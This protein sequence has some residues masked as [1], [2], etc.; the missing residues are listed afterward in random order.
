MNQTKKINLRKLN[1]KDK[2]D[3]LTVWSSN[4]FNFEKYRVN[5]PENKLKYIFE[6]NKKPLRTGEFPTN[7]NCYNED[8]CEESRKFTQRK[9]LKGKQ[10]IY[11]YAYELTLIHEF[12]KGNT[13]PEL[14]KYKH[15]KSRKYL[16]TSKPTRT[17]FYISSYHEL[18][19]DIITG[20]IS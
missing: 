9:P 12:K 4:R 13:L 5:K 15:W 8:C 17:F 20:K 18:V 6:F 11:E 7:S 3:R 1:I 2:T 14:Q 16:F 10:Q 19:K